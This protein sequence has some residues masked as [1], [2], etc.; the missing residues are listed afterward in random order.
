[1]EKITIYFVLIILAIRLEGDAFQSL[2]SIK[3]R[4]GNI[5]KTYDKHYKP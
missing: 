2:N 3:E 5:I 1:M 4:N